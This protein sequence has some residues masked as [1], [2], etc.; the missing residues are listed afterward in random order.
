VLVVRVAAPSRD[1][2]E[3]VPIIAKKSQIDLEDCGHSPNVE[4]PGEFREALV[5]HVRRPARL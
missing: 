5:A 4:H 1:D 2:A 3:V